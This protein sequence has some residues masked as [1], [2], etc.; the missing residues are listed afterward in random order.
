MLSLLIQIFHFLLLLVQ[1]T[2]MAD[3]SGD[4]KNI[5]GEALKPCSMNPLTGDV[6]T[7]ISIYYCFPKAGQESTTT[8]DIRK[9]HFQ[10]FD[11]EK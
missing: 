5:L 7:P 1:H 8:P 9:K 4:Q 3:Q 11:L 2:V 6:Y 10:I